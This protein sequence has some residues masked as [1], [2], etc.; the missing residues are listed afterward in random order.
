MD[1]NEQKNG[2]DIPDL[3]DFFKRMHFFFYGTFS[4]QERRVLNRYIMA[5]DGAVEEYMTDKVQYV[6]THSEWDDNFDQALSDNTTLAFI[7]PKWIY[8][9]Y[10]KQKIVP[11]QPYVVVPK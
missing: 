4:A 3:P 9:C 1:V 6:L 10:D 11:Y 2:T 8:T 5:Y 7:R